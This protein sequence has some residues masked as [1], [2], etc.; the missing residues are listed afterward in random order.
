MSGVTLSSR[1]VRPGDLYAALPGTRVHGAR[2][3]AQAADAGAVA[4]LT[5]PAGREIL[6]AAGVLL[7]CVVVPEPRAVLGGLAAWLYGDPGKS[8]STYGVT[9]TN[10]KTTTTF[11]IDSALRALGR[12]TGLIGTIEIRVAGERVT[13]TGTTPEAPDLHALLAVMV[14]RGVEACSMEISSH[15]L[16]Q[17][18]TDGLVVDVAGFTNLSQDHL[19]YHGTLKEYFAAKALLFTPAHAARGVVCVDDDW[20]LRLLDRAEIPVVSVRTRPRKPRA[21]GRLAGDRRPPAR[22]RPDR[23]RRRLTGRVAGV[24]QP[25]A[26]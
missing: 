24:D 14:E 17:H 18:R 22:R 20:G 12:T 7:P 4:V 25:A 10:G 3:A 9:G 21:P 2:F 8:L 5:D 23:R 19:D 16:V 26:R 11:L 1:T 15:A 13:S 6:S